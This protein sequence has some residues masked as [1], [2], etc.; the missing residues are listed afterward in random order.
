MLAIEAQNE[1]YQNPKCSSKD[2]LLTTLNEGAWKYYLYNE[3]IEKYE[4]HFGN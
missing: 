1:L 4:S 2:L 3:S